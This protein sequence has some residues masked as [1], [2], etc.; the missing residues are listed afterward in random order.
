MRVVSPGVGFEMYRDSMRE[1]AACLFFFI[2]FFLFLSNKLLHYCFC[3]IIYKYKYL[4]IMLGCS[5]WWWCLS[6]CVMMML[7]RRRSVSFQCGWRLR[8]CELARYRSMSGI[9]SKRG[10]NAEPSSWGLLNAGRCGCKI[11][12]FG[13]K[14]CTPFHYYM[15]MF[16]YLT[17]Q[18]SSKVY[19][20][21]SWHVKIN[22]SQRVF[23]TFQFSNGHLYYIGKTRDIREK[24]T[25]NWVEKVCWVVLDNFNT[26]RR[27]CHDNEENKIKLC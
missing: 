11:S 3:I 9:R 25:F 18:Y 1:M 17:W 14:C 16:C 5:W 6:K 20:Q 26:M 27:S 19:W 10:G 22:H 23:K 12:S 2:F 15:G 21:K 24:K 8:L 13:I 4:Y 7:L